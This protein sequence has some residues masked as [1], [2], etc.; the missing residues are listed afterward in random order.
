MKKKILEI[1]DN[2]LAAAGF[3]VMDGD[4]DSIIIRDAEHDADF[5]IKV[6]DLAP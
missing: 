4:A 2:S 1:I 5:A 3:K 6:E